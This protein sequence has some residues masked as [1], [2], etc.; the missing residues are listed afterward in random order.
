MEWNGQA[1]RPIDAPIQQAVN[2]ARTLV[3]AYVTANA[4]AVRPRANISH[5]NV[6]KV[7]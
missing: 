7:V 2:P 3:T 6:E 5:S 4:G 1:R